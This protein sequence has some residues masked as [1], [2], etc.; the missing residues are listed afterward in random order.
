MSKNSE[1]VGGNERMIKA[2]LEAF[3]RHDLDVI[4][5]FFSE[6]CTFDMPKGPSAFG[7]RYIGKAGVREGIASRFRGIPDVHYGDDR[8]FFSVSGDR[9]VLEWLVTGTSVSGERIEARGC[10]LLEFG[11]DGK[12]KHKDTYWKIVQPKV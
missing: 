4:M 1:T 7:T 10:D 8:C 6:D 11:S 5:S 9:G 3:N 2:F 12:I